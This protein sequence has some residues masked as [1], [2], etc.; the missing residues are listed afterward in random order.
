M[1]GSESGTRMWRGEAD[2]IPRMVYINLERLGLI[3]LWRMPGP[4]SAVQRINNGEA[5]PFMRHA[6][7]LSS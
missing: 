4:A 6:N 2:G 3:A 5:S 7:P 1:Q